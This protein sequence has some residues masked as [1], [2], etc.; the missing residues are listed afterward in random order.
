ML[1][2]NSALQCLT[3]HL[4]KNVEGTTYLQAVLIVQ[5]TKFSM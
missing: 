3:N 4:K 5:I 1:S 2:Y